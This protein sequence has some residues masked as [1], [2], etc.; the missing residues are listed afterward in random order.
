MPRSARQ[1][2]SLSPSSRS[3]FGWTCIAALLATTPLTACRNTSKPTAS[4]SAPATDQ[5]PPVGNTDTT[6]PHAFP[7]VDRVS[8][9]LEVQW[10][11]ADDTD[12][13]VGAALF[14][15]AD[16]AAPLPPERARALIDNGLR[17]VRVPIA[18]LAELQTRLPTLRT[19][20]RTWFGSVVDWKPIFTGLR[21][22]P[23][24]RAAEGNVRASTSDPVLLINGVPERVAPGVL[25]IIGRSWTA[26]STAGEALRLEAAVQLQTAV[27]DQAVAALK[28]KNAGPTSVVEEGRVFASTSLDIALPAGFAYVLVP[29]S[30]GVEWKDARARKRAK[31]EAQA[32]EGSGTA[33]PDVAPPRTIG[34]AMMSVQSRPPTGPNDSPALRRPIKA[35]VVLVPR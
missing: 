16:G 27:R 18:K 2:P 28:L 23:T 5:L 9:G 33:G 25:R 8:K 21:L 17:L 35:V 19:L 15:L 11:V 31:A 20:E 6:S 12:G 7:L 3:G 13:A 10:W 22:E 26:S 34:E 29:E 14:D 24:I 30:P 1:L 32:G 4:K